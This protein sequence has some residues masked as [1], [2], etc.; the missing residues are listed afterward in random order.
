M[1]PPPTAP[2]PNNP[3]P[4]SLLSLRAALILLAA[5]VLGGTVGALTWASGGNTATSLLAGLTTTGAG[6][7]SL[8][9]LIGH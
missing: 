5:T 7:A 3:E 8:H 9:R 2:D 4:G 6:I 1:T